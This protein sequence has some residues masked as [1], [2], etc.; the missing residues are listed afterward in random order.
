[1]ARVRDAGNRMHRDTKG[2]HV[3]MVGQIRILGRGSK[4][5][6]GF[7]A[8]DTS[9]CTGHGVEEDPSGKH[10]MIDLE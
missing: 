5:G 2:A 7:G 1:M 9:G 6:I 4:G 10:L 3:L 8:K